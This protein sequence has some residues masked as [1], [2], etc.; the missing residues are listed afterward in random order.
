[1]GYRIVEAVLVGK[2]DGSRGNTVAKA[3]IVGDGGGLW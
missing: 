2:V 1:M 3:E